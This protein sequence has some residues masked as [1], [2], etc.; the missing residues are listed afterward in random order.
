MNIS[1]TD[2]ELEKTH[3]KIKFK[4]NLECERDMGAI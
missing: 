2:M 1:I 3:D 4:W